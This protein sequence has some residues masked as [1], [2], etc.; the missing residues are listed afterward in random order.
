[1]KLD[2]QI[3]DVFAVVRT[4]PG[5]DASREFGR[6]GFP[7]VPLVQQELSAHTAVPSAAR[8]S[9]TIACRS[10]LTRDEEVEVLV[11]EAAEGGESPVSSRNSRNWLRRKVVT[12]SWPAASS[13]SHQS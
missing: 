9:F 6:R 8:R 12:S 2:G 11:A 10:G 4:E 13:S 7:R 5:V 1:M 3:D